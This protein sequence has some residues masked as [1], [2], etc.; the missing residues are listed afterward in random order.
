MAE[1][2]KME[3]DV[4]T[5]FL[6]EIFL[7]E[8]LTINKKNFNSVRQ[9][10]LIKRKFIK[11]YEQDFQEKNSVVLIL[12]DKET[13]NAIFCLLMDDNGNIIGMLNFGETINFENME[14][15]IHRL[16][17]LHLSNS[18]ALKILEQFYKYKKSA[19]AGKEDKIKIVE[20]LLGHED[21]TKKLEADKLMEDGEEYKRQNNFDMAERSFSQAVNLYEKSLGAYDYETLKALK[22]LGFVFEKLG[23]YDHV[24]QIFEQVSARYEIALGPNDKDTIENNEILGDIFSKQGK[25]QEAKAEYERALTGYAKILEP[26]DQTIIKLNKK[27]SDLEQVISSTDSGEDKGSSSRK[28]GR[29]EE[30]IRVLIHR[31]LEDRNKDLL[32]IARTKIQQ[33]GNNTKIVDDAIDQIDQDQMSEGKNAPE[34]TQSPTAVGGPQV[35]GS[36]SSR[37]LNFQEKMKN[38]KQA[39]DM[40]QQVVDNARKGKGVNIELLRAAKR[41]YEFIGNKH[42]VKMVQQ[43]IDDPN[44]LLRSPVSHPSSHSYKKDLDDALKLFNED[45]TN[46][47]TSTDEKKIEDIKEKINMALAYPIQ[48]ALET[49]ELD[50][51]DLETLLKILKGI[52]ETGS[53]YDRI[54]GKLMYKKRGG[55]KKVRSTKKYASVKKH[56]T[57]RRNKNEHQNKNNYKSSKKNRIIK[58]TQR[59]KTIKT[60]KTP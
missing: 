43:M 25:Y 28:R 52:V 53:D 56:T 33:M 40:V 49:N 18:Y 4:V 21:E 32:N 36:N 22:K 34:T 10:D 46:S 37:Q 16:K 8:Y 1:E 6:E 58:S 54:K 2:K 48:Q 13:N 45:Y 15:Q 27:I 9:N 47:R 30:E 29:E 31:G 14:S 5:I 24:I 23:N 35:A 59:K 26:N 41:I 19:D 39:D 3:K 7:D 51:E 55:K 17:N 50:E 60:H 38:E 44:F 11:K 20:P 12:K 57:T 42:K